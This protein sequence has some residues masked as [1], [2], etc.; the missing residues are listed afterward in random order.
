[1]ELFTIG[2]A[3]VVAAPKDSADVRQ[4]IKKMRSRD[5]QLDSY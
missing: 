4:Y 3:D 5:P 1:M 2:C